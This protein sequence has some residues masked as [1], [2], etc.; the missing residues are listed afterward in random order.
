MFFGKSK[1]NR[2]AIEAYKN[3]LDSVKDELAGFKT[4]I[5]SD[6]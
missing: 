5:E 4:K 3:E 2:E 6:L 1:R